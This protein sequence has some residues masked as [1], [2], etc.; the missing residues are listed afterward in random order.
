MT[1]KACYLV[2]PK[3]NVFV[4]VVCF[5]EFPPNCRY[6]VGSNPKECFT[7]VWN[8]TGCL[9]VGLLNP[10]SASE[11]KLKFLRSFDLRCFLFVFIFVSLKIINSW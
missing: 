8:T 1:L 11:E 4:L 7:A 10:A 9:Q 2:V 3:R 6:F 5:L